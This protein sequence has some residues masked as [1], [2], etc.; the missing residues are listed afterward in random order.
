MKRI[1]VYDTTLRDGT[2][3]AGVA[4]S[5]EDK[6]R[7]ARRLDELGFD[8]IEGGWPGSNPKDLAFF[9]QARA[10][11]WRHARI[12]AFGSTRR[13]GVRPEEDANLRLLVDAGTPTVTIFGKSWDLHVRE[14]LRATLEEN[15]A[16]IRESVAFLRAA[17]REVIYDAEHF[18]DG[19]RANRDYALATLR[20]A[21]EAGADCLVLCDTNGGSLPGQ[22]RDGVALV[23]REVGG[24]IGI[25]THNDAELAVANALAAVEAGCVHVQGTINGYGE[26]CGNANLCSVIP[27]I[28]LKLG[29][30]AL[31]P[32]A[33]VHLTGLSRLVAELANMAPDDYQPY[34]GANAFAHKGGVHVSAVMAD[35]VMYEHVPPEVI[36]NARR[37]VVS[38]LSGRAT[39]LYK[40]GEMGLHL[41]RSRPEIQAVL[42][43]LKRLEFEGYQFEGAEASF[44]LLLRRAALGY[45]PGFEIKAFHVAVDQHHGQ[46]TARAIV[47]VSVRGQ[48]A[49][50]SAEGNGPVHALDRALRAALERFHPEL[51]RVRLVDYKVRVLNA[52]AATAARVRVLITST[53]GQRHWG[54]VGVS[55]NVVLASAQALADSLE[56]ASLVAAPQPAS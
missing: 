35:P 56:Y 37:V 51:A 55:E 44:E 34:V 15:L 20:A 8:Y 41:D 18:F 19:L 28:R 29:L 53:D 14:A 7:I 26:R 6:V 16:M 40:A 52:E 54:T 24:P 4:F 25:H 32:D 9:E 38:D 33:L 31:R 10:V 27:G 22:V 39:V 43:D 46:C 1:A 50:A 48:E 36:G 17:G 21:R 12:A 13:A 2:Q 45:V 3:A 47:R 5:A 11:P 23:A 30:D 42:D 49:G